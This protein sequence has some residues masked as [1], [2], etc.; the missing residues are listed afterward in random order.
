[1]LIAGRPYKQP[2]PWV[3]FTQ[4]FRLSITRNTV[5][6]I[7]H[8]SGSNPEAFVSRKSNS[9][10]PQI[11]HHDVGFVRSFGSVAHQDSQRSQKCSTVL[12]MRFY[13]LEPHR[14]NGPCY[15]LLSGLDLPK[16]RSPRMKSGFYTRQTTVCCPEP[17]YA[18]I[19]NASKHRFGRLAKRCHVIEHTPDMRKP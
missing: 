3:Y 7:G 16:V 1:V 9:G 5:F 14:E 19:L 12:P 15:P 11:R 18:P 2:S 10:S 17:Y 13:L 8:P 6:T 4:G